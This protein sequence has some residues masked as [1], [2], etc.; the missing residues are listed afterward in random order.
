[1]SKRTR[2]AV[3]AVVQR[4]VTT[5]GHDENKYRIVCKVDNHGLAM[6][7]CERTEAPPGFT[8]LQKL[9]WAS[10]LVLVNAVS[11]AA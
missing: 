1:M 9:L 11:K 7:W 5:W 10:E 6:Y 8:S 4:K 2:F 3:G